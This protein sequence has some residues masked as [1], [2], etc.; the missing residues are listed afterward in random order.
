MN[1]FWRWMRHRN[2]EHAVAVH[3]AGHVVVA[4]S[5]QLPVHYATVGRR[6]RGVTVLRALRSHAWLD[7]AVRRN[8]RFAFAELSGAR[9]RLVEGHIVLSWGG[10]AADKLFFGRRT[11]GYK[12]SDDLQQAEYLADLLSDVHE[13]SRIY[14]ARFEAVAA[15]IVRQRRREIAQIASVLE[16]SPWRR[17]PGDQLLSEMNQV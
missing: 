1:A 8:R 6:S 10:I 13:P 7:E 15:R 3:E 12:E 11:N 2:Y 4:D 14:V 17:V 16:R 9:R 5:Y